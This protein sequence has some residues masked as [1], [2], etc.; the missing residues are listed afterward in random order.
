MFPTHTLY[1]PKSSSECENWGGFSVIHWFVTGNTATNF[2]VNQRSDGAHTAS[3][4]ALDNREKDTFSGLAL[5]S[6]HANFW[7]IA[8]K[9]CSVSHTCTL[10][11]Y[12]SSIFNVNVACHTDCMCWCV[13]A[14]RELCETE[15]R[16]PYVTCYHSTYLSMGATDLLWTKECFWCLC[17]HYFKMKLTNSHKHDLKIWTCTDPRF[18][19]S[20]LLF[21]YSGGS[22]PTLT[23]SRALACLHSNV[24]DTCY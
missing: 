1:K 2:W 21:P 20:C 9:Q 24:F 18:G 7:G 10:Q 16:L 4:G 23:G 15:V 3:T 19:Y 6:F 12:K 22:H 13:P 17:S 5:A 11:V 8:A 14:L